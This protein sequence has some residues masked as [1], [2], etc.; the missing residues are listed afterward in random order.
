MPSCSKCK[1]PAVIHVRYSGEHLCGTH[2]ARFVGE[3]VRR[4]LRHQ[5]P[6]KKGAR[7]AVALSG[8]KDSVATLHLL[9]DIFHE[10]PTIELFAVSVD[11]GIAGYRKPS[12]D[13]AE[14]ECKALDIP[15]HVESYERMAGFSMDTFVQLDAQTMPCAACGVL[16]RRAINRGAQAVGATHVATGHN[17]DDVAQTILM[18]TIRGDT[19]RLAR[20]GPH[21]RVI[22]GL[23]PRIMP[24][25]SIPE[26]EVALYCFIK[27]YEVH[28]GECP[29]S[30]G[31]TRGRFR[32]MLLDLEEAEPG[33]RHS[34]LKGY[35]RMADALLAT[36]PTRQLDA[37]PGCGEPASGGTCRPC[38][39][40][41]RAQRLKAERDA[42]A[43]ADT[44]AG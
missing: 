21:K 32:D 12:L 39:V 6:F 22:P 5:G 38:A 25:R 27:G 44:T 40:I 36:L 30:A 26:R 2:H 43:G 28:E 14:R 11:E 35:D 7:I 18:N 41:D 16:R 4:D 19:D 24:L 10:N 1:E 9:H 31:A 8:G 37:C 15:M 33:T 42:A 13:I 23:I 17:L 34:L 29:H 3:R 20:L